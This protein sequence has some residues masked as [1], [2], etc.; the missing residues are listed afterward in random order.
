M[1]V[2]DDHRDVVAQLVEGFEQL[3]GDG[4]GEALERLVEQPHAKVSRKRAGDRP[5]LPPPPPEKSRRRGPAPREAREIRRD[6]GGGSLGGAGRVT[7]WG[8]AGLGLPQPV[9]PGNSPPP[10][11]TYP[12]PRRAI[13]GEARPAVFSPAT[14]IEP[15]PGGAMPITVF[16][17]VDFPAPLR[18]S[19]ATIS[20]SRT[21]SETALRMWLL[22]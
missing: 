15:A 10:G 22:P 16:S 18:P 8:R 21:S 4:G 12:M 14:R 5:Q 20:C 11:G 9:R 13:S 7:G 1:M 3:L 17:S 6:G 19:N 2:D